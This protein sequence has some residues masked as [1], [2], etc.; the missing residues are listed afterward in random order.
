MV[1]INANTGKPE[2]TWKIEVTRGDRTHTDVISLE[3]DDISALPNAIKQL[4]AYGCDLSGVIEAAH[5]IEEEQRKR[6]VAE[7]AKAKLKAALEE[8]IDNGQRGFMR[9]FIVAYA[10]ELEVIQVAEGIEYSNGKVHVAEPWVFAGGFARSM[11]AYK[12]SLETAGY[13]YY[14]QYID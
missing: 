12:A 10:K 4:S 11:K 6:K 13:S 2:G 5:A 1:A 3:V 9:R 8:Y 7:E 14:V